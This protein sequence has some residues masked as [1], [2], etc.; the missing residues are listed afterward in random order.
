MADLKACFVNELGY[1]DARTYIQTGNVLFTSGK[2]AATLEKEISTQFEKTFGF[3]VEVIVR[4]APELK[5]IAEHGPF[6]KSTDSAEITRYVTFLKQELTPEQLA[7]VAAIDNPGETHQIRGKE[8]YSE[9]DRS[10]SENLVFSGNFI[11]KKLKS[12]AT[13]RN[14]KVVR[15]LADMRVE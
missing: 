2:A 4:T 10:L 6:A 1:T 14:W 3:E 15:A 12:I 13:A 9:L 8:V 7:K 11:D 5:K